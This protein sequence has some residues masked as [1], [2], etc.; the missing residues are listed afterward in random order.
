MNP[1]LLANW[2]LFL[3]VTIYGLYL[4]V[5]VVRTR[6]AYIKMGKKFE[7]DGKIKRRLQKIGIY[8]FG[9]KKLLKDKKSGAIHVMMFYGFILVQF[10]AIDFIWKGLA[11]DS[12]LPLGP[13]YPGFTF[14]QEIV[15]LTIIVAVIW[16]F[17]RRYI[18]KLVRLKRSFKAGLVLIFIG[19]LMFT[20]LVGNGMGMIWHGHE[21][22]WT[23]PVATVIASA[24]A[25][26]PPA[27]AATVFF[28]M[29]W[30]HLLILLTFLVYVPQSKHAHLLAAPV[31]VFLSREDPPGKLKPINFEMD[32][33]AD[34]EDV[35]FG[36]G[37]IEELN[38]LQMIDLY[39][40]VECGRC[41]N[42]CPASG[43]GKMLSP[44]DLLIKMRDHLTEKGAAVTGQ[45]PWVPA[46]AFSGTEGNTLAQMARTK[47]TD[48][49]AAA[50]EA[51]HNKNL[52]G[53]VITEEELWACTTC[54][55]CEDA[56]PVMNEHV[57][58]IIDLRRY[59]VLTEGKM[60]PDGQ[61]AMM[62]IERQGNPWGLSK[63]E[64]EDWRSLDEEAHIPTV[65]ELKKSGEE[66]EYLFW[67]SSMGSY[68]NRSQKIA[69]AFAKLMNKAGI[70]FAILGNK[71]QNSGDTARRMGNEF[72]FQE[73]AEKN[74]KEFEKNDVKK[75]ITIDPH[76]YNI[77]KNEYPDFGLEAEVYHHTEM[78]SE[79]LKEGRLKPEGVVNEKITYHDSCYLGRYNEVYQPPREVLEMIP[80]VEVVEMKRNR[81]NG[82][83]CGAGG[84]MMW[85]E[86]KS[87]NRV[88]VARTE[89]ALE[90]E[91][92][93][94]S[95]GCPFC[96]TMLSDGTKA[97][98]VEEEVST[99]DIAEILAKSIFESTEEKTA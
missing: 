19:T 39:A 46:Y 92:T 43:S 45:S 47:G 12:H 77:F 87:G 10:G 69:V 68:D 23:E 16:A 38:Q 79:W 7:F 41:T 28:I 30:I 73:L 55:N 37:K 70:K 14:F 90:V 50:V 97:K 58:K 61:R 63:K 4:F 5:S 89:Q 71:E 51:A 1:L 34:E 85:M 59:L 78:L 9:Q 48:E 3:G 98:E 62:N 54:R 36:V 42:V 21:G 82:M 22:A 99:M 60:D 93:M 33:E 91:P 2:I 83:C 13:F 86:E 6:I 40:C 95:S 53:D 32:E 88:N 74:M 75:I 18:E 81:S 24:F 67:V 76:A 64:R 94:I 56:C 57:D 27:A 80:G 17:Y 8:V 52:I 65:K 15:T 35:S 29:W 31:N 25:W 11:P 20:V 26:L 96:L 49:A 66:F 72:L 44:M 84:G